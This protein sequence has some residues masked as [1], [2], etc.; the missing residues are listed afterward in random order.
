MSWSKAGVIEKA[1]VC[2][3]AAHEQTC[4]HN[5]STGGKLTQAARRELMEKNSYCILSVL[6]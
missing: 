4:R 1:A 5:D 3:A 6:S 2:Q